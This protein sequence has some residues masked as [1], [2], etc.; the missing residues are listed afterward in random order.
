V[1][2]RREFRKHLDG[3]RARL[4]REHRAASDDELRELYRLREE[5]LSLDYGPILKGPLP[6]LAELEI[7][8]GREPMATEPATTEPVELEPAASNPLR[9][10]RPGP[11][12]ETR[13][14]LETRRELDRLAD[15]YLDDRGSMTQEDIEKQ[16][17]PGATRHYVRQA[18]KRARARRARARG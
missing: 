10:F 12:P 4:G 14:P 6:S 18:L 16:A 3:L 15:Q 13:L 9:V 7:E 8:F 2:T 17:G 5:A 1:I 11:E